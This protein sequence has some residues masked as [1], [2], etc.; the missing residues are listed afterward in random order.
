MYATGMYSYLSKIGFEIKF[1]ILDTNHPD[2][3]YLREEGCEV[4]VNVKVKSCLQLPRRP[5]GGE[6]I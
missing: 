4:K 1:L 2:T 5:T 6:E 3:L